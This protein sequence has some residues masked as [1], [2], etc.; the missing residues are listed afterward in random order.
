MPRTTIADK[1]AHCAGRTEELRASADAQAHAG[2]I[3]HVD[4]VARA[5][6]REH[7]LVQVGSELR[8]LRRRGG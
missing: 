7:D 3:C 5:R 1:L 4:K 6:L 2:K 8:P